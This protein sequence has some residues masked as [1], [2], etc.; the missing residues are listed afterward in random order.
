MRSGEDIERERIRLYA[1]G[2]NDAMRGTPCRSN[3]LAYSLGYLDAT[4]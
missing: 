4:R 3:E 1:R 2:W